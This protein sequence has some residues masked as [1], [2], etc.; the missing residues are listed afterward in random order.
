[1]TLPSA[2]RGIGIVE[3]RSKLADPHRRAFEHLP[4]YLEAAFLHEFLETGAHV[5]QAPIQGA[6]THREERSDLL[7][8]DVD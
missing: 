5:I 7:G 3:R 2:G 8:L 6:S 1:M 4:D